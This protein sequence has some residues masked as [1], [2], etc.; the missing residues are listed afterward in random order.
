MVVELIFEASDDPHH[1]NRNDG[2]HKAERHVHEALAARNGRHEAITGGKT[3]A[4]QKE[5]NP[6]F[7]QNEVGGLRHIGDD[8]QLRP[9]VPQ[10]NGHDERAARQ[11]Q[12]QRYRHSR[13]RNRNRSQKDADQHPE[14]NHRHIRRIEF[15]GLIPQRHRKAL[16]RLLGTHAVHHVPDLQ[17][18]LL[19]RKERHPRTEHT[20][21][22]DAV[23]ARQM[24]IRQ[25]GSVHC[26]LGYRHPPGNQRRLL[27]GQV[28]SVINL[29]AEGDDRILRFLTRHNPQMIVHI[30]RGVRVRTRDF[31]RVHHT[32]ADEGTADEVTDFADRLAV[33]AGIRHLHL[34]VNRRVV[35]GFFRQLPCPIFFRHVDAEDK[36]QSNRCPDDSH[37]PQGIR[38]GVRHGYIVS[39]VP[40]HRQ[41]FLRCAQTRRI[42]HCPVVHAE[43]LR[44]INLVGERKVKKDRDDETCRDREERQKV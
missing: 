10:Q 12:F 29:T 19:E 38:A 33:D 39:L 15:A 14:E 36:A 8:S 31:A 40:Q 23:V 1:Q 2:N 20:S 9:E 21:D 11:T 34:K 42:R 37:D 26:H 6:Q 43:H 24:Q 13:K 32:T 28:R 3:H 44:E 35:R 18:K 41:S 4:R 16:H 7:P 22:V 25:G 17:M 27:G 30:D 5:R